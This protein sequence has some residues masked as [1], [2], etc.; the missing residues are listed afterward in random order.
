MHRNPK[1]WREVLDILRRLGANCIRTN[2]SHQT[3]RFPDGETFVCV[4]NRLHDAPSI[5]VL[6]KFRRLRA[7]REETNAEPSLL[8]W[9]GS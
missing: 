1:S 6:V 8:G 3:W 5:G 7:R 9:T 4:V 2:G